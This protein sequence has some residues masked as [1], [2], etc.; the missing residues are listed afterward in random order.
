[1]RRIQRYHKIPVHYAVEVE[2]DNYRWCR[3]RRR[4]LTVDELFA[5]EKSYHRYNAIAR[6]L[7]QA[8]RWA[9]RGNPGLVLVVR[10]GGTFRMWEVTAT[11]VRKLR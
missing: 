11:T 7:R 5:A 6:T 10:V 9:R 4:W 3:R 1:M 2:S 8:I